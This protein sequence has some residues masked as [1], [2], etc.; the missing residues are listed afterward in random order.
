MQAVIC[1]LRF[2]V[3]EWRD[4]YRHFVVCGYGMRFGVL[5]ERVSLSRMRARCLGFPQFQIP[6]VI[7]DN[8]LSFGYPHS[9]QYI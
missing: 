5:V 1:P 4:R 2:K 8:S 3:F 9:V 6:R 7:D